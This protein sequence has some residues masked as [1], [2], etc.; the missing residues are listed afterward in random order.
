MLRASQGFNC[1]WAQ[2]LDAAT[3]RP[4][5]SPVP[6]FHAHGAR[7]LT[8]GGSVARERLVFSLAERTGNIWMAQWNGRR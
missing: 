1:I 7:A 6:I 8:G 4:V 3:K 2:R 5:G